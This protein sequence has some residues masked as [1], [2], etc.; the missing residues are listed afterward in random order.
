MN[1][2][3][4]KQLFS[5]VANKAKIAI[6]SGAVQKPAPGIVTTSLLIRSGLI[7]YEDVADAFFKNVD[8]SAELAKEDSAWS[9]TAIDRIFSEG[10]ATIADGE[11]VTEAAARVASRLDETPKTYIIRSLLIGLEDACELIKFGLVAIGITTVTPDSDFGPYLKAGVPTKY[12]YAQVEAAGID[13]E[14]AQSRAMA[15]IDRHLAILNAFFADGIPSR[16]YLSRR[17]ESDF[18]VTLTQIVEDEL[19]PER[20]S[21]SRTR[22]SIFPIDWKSCVTHPSMEKV[23][24]LLARSDEFAEHV[25]SALQLAG[26]ATRECTQQNAFLLL[27]VA[28]ESALMAVNSETEISHQFAVRAAL[29][30]SGTAKQRRGL[31]E[32]VKRLYRLRSAIVHRG[33]ASIT[34]RDVTE[35]SDVCK[36]CLIVLSTAKEFETFRTLKELDGWFLDRL[37]ETP[38]PARE[39]TV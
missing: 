7:F 32:Q 27:A 35:M 30:S 33:S 16:R 10:L 21:S 13:S 24:G 31:Y 12:H 6:E 9:K 23:G 38:V 39:G 34:L 37:F 22:V 29:L 4:I 26:E 28:L 25:V 8:E 18:D 5:E 2:Q 3:R 11:S 14:S 15:I 20:I 1:K 19:K 36:G 17:F